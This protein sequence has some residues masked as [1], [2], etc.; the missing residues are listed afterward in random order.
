MVC[1]DDI[2]TK[3]TAVSLTYEQVKD[4]LL[5]LVH[6]G[7]KPHDPARLQEGM[8][9]LKLPSYNTDPSK[10]ITNILR[11]YLSVSTQLGI[12]NLER[13]T[14]NTLSNWFWEDLSSIIESVY[15]SL[16]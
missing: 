2:D 7:N 14:Q 10:L 16:R 9:G 11:T 1:L 5:G 15:A 3:T 12:E 4:Y 13:R 8:D 6:Q